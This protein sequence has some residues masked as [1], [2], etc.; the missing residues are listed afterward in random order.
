MD[1]D[2]R[3]VVQSQVL[4]EPTR[5]QEQST[6]PTNR[7]TQG[8]TT[9][10]SENESGL[11]SHVHDNYHQVECRFIHQSDLANVATNYA[12]FLF[13][14]YKGKNGTVRNYQCKWCEL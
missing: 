7:D 12:Y 5:D 14:N 9:R 10:T 6:R 3:T 4:T 2:E 1:S 8:G 13:G 11:Q